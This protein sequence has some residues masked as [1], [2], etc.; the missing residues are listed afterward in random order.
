MDDLRKNGEGYLDLTAYEAMKK[1]KKR[2]GTI[3]QTLTYHIF[4]LRNGWI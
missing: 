2:G 3:P 1:C 4:H